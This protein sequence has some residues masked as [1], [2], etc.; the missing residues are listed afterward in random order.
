MPDVFVNPLPGLDISKFLAFDFPT[1]PLSQ[2]KNLYEGAAYMGNITLEEPAIQEMYDKLGEPPQ[3]QGHPKIRELDPEGED[4]NQ[5]ERFRDHDQVL[6]IDRR[7]RINHTGRLSGSF[8]KYIADCGFCSKIKVI[9]TDVSDNNEPTQ[10]LLET[11]DDLTPKPQ[12]LNVWFWL[13]PNKKQELVFNLDVVRAANQYFKA[14][15]VYKLIVKWEF[16]SKDKPRERLPIS[17]YDESISFEVISQ[18]ADF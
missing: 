7:I 6:D 18:T 3:H 13:N 9:C 2:G 1:L 10:V 5:P 11:V 12:A 8:V 16:W 14:E 17:G 4:P 15:H